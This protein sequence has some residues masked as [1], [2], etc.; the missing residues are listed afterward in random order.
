MTLDN[1]RKLELS[2]M[3]RAFEIACERAGLSTARDG[4]EITDDHA[5]LA[6]VV[7]SLVEQGYTDVTAIAEQATDVLAGRSRIN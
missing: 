1:L 7:Q 5:R 4:S 6:F 2:L 3:R